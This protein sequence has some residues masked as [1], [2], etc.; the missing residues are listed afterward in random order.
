MGHCLNQN[1]GGG[2]GGR[3]CEGYIPTASIYR[4]QTYTFLEAA[5][6]DESPWNVLINAKPILTG[7]ASIYRKCIFS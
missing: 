6:P 7:T 1:G 2:S 5:I 4:G 3:E